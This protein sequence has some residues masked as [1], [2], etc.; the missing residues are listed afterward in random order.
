MKHMQ[1]FP[2]P[3][4]GHDGM[5]LRDYF[6]AKAMQVLIAATV[7]ANSE[8]NEEDAALVSYRMADAMIKERDE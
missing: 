8:L 5:T 7:S 1:A 4:N 3:Y 6:A 2:M